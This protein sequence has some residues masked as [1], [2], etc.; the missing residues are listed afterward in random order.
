MVEQNAR[1]AIR[2]SDR[3]Y[4]MVEGRNYMAGTAGALLAD[5]AIAEAF[6]GARRRTA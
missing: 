1:A 3:A 4:V 2:A 5:P 6:L